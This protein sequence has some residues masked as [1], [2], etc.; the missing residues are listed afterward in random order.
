MVQQKLLLQTA[1]DALDDA[2]YVPDSTPTFQ[3][4]SFG[5]YVGVATGDYVDNLREDIDVYYST[6]ET[7]NAHPHSMKVPG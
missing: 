1:L 5:C 4:N 2:G 7:D 3:R 6:G